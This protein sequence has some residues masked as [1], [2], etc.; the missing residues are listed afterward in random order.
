V[1]KVGLTNPLQTAAR[2]DPLTQDHTY[3]FT[4]TAS[5]G[6]GES[7]PSSPVSAVAHAAPPAPPRSLRASPSGDGRVRL[8]WQ[9]PVVDPVRGVTRAVEP[10]TT[11]FYVVYQRDLTAGDA[12][13]TRWAYPTADLQVAADGLHS[14]HTYL[15]SVA[16]SGPGG[17][18]PMATPVRVSASGGLPAMV[19]ALTGA[20]GDGA[21]VL[22]WSP[23]GGRDG[24]YLIY[25]R[26]LTAGDAD[27]T[28]L[29]F[30]VVGDHF[31]DIG[32]Y[33][34][35]LYLYRVAAGNAHGEG[36]PSP[37][38]L[39]EPL[40]PPPPAPED[41]H[42][43]PGGGS[44]VLTWTAAQA[45]DYY[46]V[47][48]RDITRGEAFHRFPLPVISGTTFTDGFLNAGDTYQYQITATNVAGEGP[49][50]NVVSI[51]STRS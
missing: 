7:V 42:A 20:A 19:A 31:T 51:V 49:A 13:F 29:L 25:R 11:L 22:T 46:F 30:P 16:A 36:A 15:L 28:R 41:L 9:A 3:E 34:G 12:G 17:D 1:Q 18:G 23:V 14:G 26:D 8:S 4:V 44:V 47:Y 38:V 40:P 39:V 32:V 48:R 33:N 10:A 5:N 21:V 37:A 45:G 2:T 50:S 27:F 43:S 6:A 24:A 35:H